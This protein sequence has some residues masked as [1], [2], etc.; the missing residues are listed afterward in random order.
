MPRPAGEV[1][2]AAIIESVACPAPVN[3]HDIARLD[4]LDEAGAISPRLN[5]LDFGRGQHQATVDQPN[6]HDRDHEPV[7]ID[8]DDSAPA[9]AATVDDL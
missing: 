3:R 5:A 9:N 4:L 6:R 1:R 2:K 7:A 8:R